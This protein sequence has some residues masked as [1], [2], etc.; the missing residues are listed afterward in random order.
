MTTPLVIQALFRA[1]AA[2]R[3]E[4]G[5]LHHSDRGS[6]YCAHAYQKLLRQFG[7]QASM[8]RKGN[9]WDNAPMESFWGAL[10]TELVHHRR[11]STREQAQREIT[12]YIEISYNRIRKQARLDY[13]SPA[14]FNQKYYAKK[15]AA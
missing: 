3:P 13:L 7:M 11:F 2:K 10:K 14:A 5:L 12:E 9:C 8:S 4:K 6:Q 15:I 1:V